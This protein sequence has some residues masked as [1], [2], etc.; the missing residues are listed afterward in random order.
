MQGLHQ[1]EH[2]P[3]I[4][5]QNTRDRAW[6]ELTCHLMKK[7]RTDL[8]AV[9]LDG[10]DKLQHLFWRFVDPDLQ[11]KDPSDWHKHIQEAVLRFLSRPR[12]QLEND[13]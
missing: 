5:L 11:E 13:V 4:E 9:V 3:W 10:P 8:T 6:T 7:D 12:P 1:G 2:E